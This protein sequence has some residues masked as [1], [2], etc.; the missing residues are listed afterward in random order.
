MHVL[1]LVGTTASGKSQMAMRLAEKFAAEIVNADSIQVYEGLDIGSAKPSAK[2]FEAIPHH[3]YSHVPKGKVYTAG[4]YEKEALRVLE[5]IKAPLA[6]VVGGSGFYLQALEKGMFDAA[7]P[8]PEIKQKMEERM[9]EEGAE[10][11]Y[12]ELMDQDPAYAK[13]ISIHDSYRILR[14]HELLLQNKMPSDL[15]QDFQVREFPYPYLKIG[16]DVPKEILR[17]RV[18]QRTEK[19][20]AEGLIEETRSLIDLGFEEWPAL[21]S[22]G[23]R[24][25]KEY[26]RGELVK[27][28]LPEKITTKTMQ[29]A[30]KQRTWFR[31]DVNI[32][33]LQKYEDAEELLQYFLKR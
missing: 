14:A 4:D 30:K 16:M 7:K 1:F 25:V 11:L 9:Q 3:L 23:Y 10:K 15:K 8:S 26:L 5:N 17:Q 18:A 32:N 31:R 21:N 24:E 19:M 29:L 2:D 33:W 12:H 27:E 13:R 28:D 22:V 20:L 6:I